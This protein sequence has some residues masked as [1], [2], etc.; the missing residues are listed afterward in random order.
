MFVPYLFQSTI[1]EIQK[2]KYIRKSDTPKTSTASEDVHLLEKKRKSEAFVNSRLRKR[3]ATI[4]ERPTALR[5]ITKSTKSVDRDIEDFSDGSS[6][7][8]TFDQIF[9]APQNFQ[10]KNNPFHPFHDRATEGFCIVRTYKRKLSASDIYIGSNQQ[11]KKRRGRRCKSGDREEISTTIQ[12]N[13]PMQSYLPIRDYSSANM[14]VNS[15]SSTPSSSSSLS[16]SSMFSLAS[17]TAASTIAINDKFC[18][19]LYNSIENRNNKFLRQRKY[20]LSIS[21][22]V[23]GVINSPIKSDCINK[24]FGGLSRIESGERYRILTKR[25]VK[26]STV[27]QYLLEWEDSGS[28]TPTPTKMKRTD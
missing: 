9:P 17:T 16:S 18:K 20:R 25:H 1:A 24:Y 23:N 8:S 2:R 12:P 26:G 22:S 5:T 10:G 15:G 21:E 7:K 11:V 19:N 3:S 28:V 6:T 13:M 27:P 14:T 4:S